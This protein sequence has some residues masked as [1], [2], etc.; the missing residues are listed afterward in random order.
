VDGIALPA[1]ADVATDAVIGTVDGGDAAADEFV[2]F[3]LSEPGRSILAS[4]GFESP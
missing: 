3:A 1:E 2:A 4:H